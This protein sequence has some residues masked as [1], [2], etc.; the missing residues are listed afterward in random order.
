M[1]S[2]QNWLAVPWNT[3]EELAAYVLGSTIRKAVKSPDL[4]QTLNHLSFNKKQGKATERWDH[5]CLFTTNFHA[6]KIKLT[7]ISCTIF[8]LWH[9]IST[10]LQLAFIT[11]TPLW[12]SVPSFSKKHIHKLP[13][14]VSAHG[15]W[16]NKKGWKLSF[17]AQS[18]ILSGWKS[19]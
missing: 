1:L 5:W 18:T 7:I 9:S 8:F 14:V 12:Y 17:N 13:L 11:F 16:E 2:W 15:E 6:L 3:K 19:E 4:P 10:Q